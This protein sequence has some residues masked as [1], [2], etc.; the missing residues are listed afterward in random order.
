MP[1]LFLFFLL[2]K[3]NLSVFTAVLLVTWAFKRNGIRFVSHASV[4]SIIGLVVGAVIRYAGGPSS[5]HHP[6]RAKLVNSTLSAEHIPNSIYLELPIPNKTHTQTLQ[7]NFYS[8]VKTATQ[9]VP[10]ERTVTFDPELFFNVLLPVIIF[11]AGYSMKRKHFF[12][13]L[14]AVMT[15]AFAGTTISSM[16][17]GG[18]L[19][20]LTRLMAIS[21]IFQLTDCFFFGAVIS[22]TDPVTV[23]AIFHDLNVD[24][25]LYALVF[26]ESVLNDAVAIVLSGAVEEYASIAEKGGYQAN[27]FFNS[28]AAEAAG[29]T[30]IVAVLFCGITQAHYTYN[31]LSPESKARTKQL[32]E[33]CNFLAEN[34]V[35]LYIGV[36]VFTFQGMKWHAAFIFSAFFA[37]FVARFFN[38]YP[39][40]LLLNL[41]RKN[42]IKFSFQHMMM[43]AGL[44]GA[45]AFALSIRNTSTEARQHMVSATMMIV[46]VTVIL[47]GG[48]TTPMLQWLK[49]RVGVDEEHEQ[50]FEPVRTHCQSLLIILSL[51]AHNPLLPLSCSTTHLSFFFLLFFF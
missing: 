21:N 38:V 31:N 42:K 15:Y 28:M 30:G 20:G 17:V 22:A 39:L 18:I 27:A 47:C 9:G 3:C 36:S 24:V 19:Y 25:D 29:L 8:K 7:Y 34:F 13:N 11:N 48:M 35:F 26:G 43:F 46:L 1:F 41:G 2:V 44:R 33:L 49:I 51:H 5:E 50:P 10:L 6:P 4:A 23:L 12:R 45:I 40:S 32:F 16:V 37:I 14:G